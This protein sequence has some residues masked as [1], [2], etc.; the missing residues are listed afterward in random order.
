[1]QD[2]VRIGI[3]GCG[4]IAKHTHMHGYSKLNEKAEVVALADPLQ[5]NL[6]ALGALHSVDTQNQYSTYQELLR[7]DDIDA[8]SICTPNYL[9]APQTIDALRAGKHVLCEKPMATNIEAAKAMVQAAEKTDRL[10]MV[11]F[12]HRY[13][14]HNQTAQQLIKQ[15]AIGK[16][17]MMRVRF[18]HD[19]PYNSWAATTDWFFR[20]EQAGGGALLDMGIHALDICRFMLGDIAQV[21]GHVGTFVKDIPVED[22]AIVSLA[23][24]ND[25]AG[26]IEVGWSSKKGVLGLEIYGSEGTLIVDYTTPIRLHQSGAGQEWVEITDAVNDAAVCEM[27]H[28]VDC[29]VQGVQPSANQLDGFTAVLLAEAVYQSA[30]TGSAVSLRD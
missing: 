26:Y 15:G 10:L 20:P 19:G 17:F 5:S 2:K 14:Q 30:Q 29:I 27:E 13:M 6:R 16:P 22:S 18:A 1:M 4:A 9:H 11:G 24:E 21:F 3:I 7:R 23:F 8:V 12:T 28:F 25:A